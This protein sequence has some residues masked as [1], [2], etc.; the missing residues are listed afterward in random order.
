MAT[1]TMRFELMRE[2]RL[3][4]TFCKVC[5][6]KR[7]RRVMVE[8]TV[9]PWNVIEEDGVKR[10]KSRHEVRNSC[11]ERVKVKAEEVRRE[12]VVCKKCE[13]Q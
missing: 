3:V 4:D 11:I 2:G 8:E 12:G 7:T 5:G 9:N 1:V 13:G 10:P 6:K